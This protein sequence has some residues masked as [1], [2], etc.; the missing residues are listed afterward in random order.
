MSW[1]LTE[2]LRRPGQVLRPTYART[3]RPLHVLPILLFENSLCLQLFQI[4]TQSLPGPAY[5][6]LPRFELPWPWPRRRCGTSTANIKRLPSPL[7]RYGQKV[8]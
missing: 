6:S 8:W 2:H 5:L 7:R 1:S 4:P 3:S